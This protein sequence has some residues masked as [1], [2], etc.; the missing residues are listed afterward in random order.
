MPKQLIAIDLD[1]VIVNHYE[2]VVEFHNSR[3]GT[4]HTLKDYISDHWGEVWGT[5]HA[6]TERRATEFAALGVVG[7]LIKAGATEAIHALSK[8]YDLAIVTVRR[9]VNVE[10]TL[11]WVDQNFPGVFRTVRFV[12]IWE[13]ENCPSK[14]DVCKEIGASYL[15]DDSSKHCRLAAEAGIHAVLFGDF[16]WN[17]VDV[18]P[19]G[20]TR[21]ND[22]PAVLEYFNVRV[23]A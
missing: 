11:A 23:A 15:I 14:A 8:N 19:E 2:T 18:L 5:D 21:C 20:V 4:N 7:R 16:A 1:D 3:Y 22:W 10:P 12:P 9:K 13:E 6:E 17:Q